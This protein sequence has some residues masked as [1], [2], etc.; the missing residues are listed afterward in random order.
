MS[1]PHSEVDVALT[2]LGPPRPGIESQ[3]AEPKDRRMLGL[4][5]AGRKQHVTIDVLAIGRALASHLSGQKDRFPHGV[6]GG[7][8]DNRPNHQSR[9]SG[10]PKAG[11]ARDFLAQR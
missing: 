9:R 6:V 3:V 11:A 5:P 7:E 1:G 4:V 8:K 10:L 2:A